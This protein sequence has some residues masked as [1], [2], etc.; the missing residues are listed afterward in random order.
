M[1]RLTDARVSAISPPTSGRLEYPDD[2]MR[3]LRLRVGAGGR[4]AWIVRTRIGE[5]QINKT[6]GPYP[7]ISLAAAE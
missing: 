7:L 1:T 2:L 6:L 4:K 3:G 5:K